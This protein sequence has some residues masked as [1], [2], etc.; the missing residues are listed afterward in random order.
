MH[1]YTEYLKL[2]V[3][4]KNIHWK[5][6]RKVLTKMANKYEKLTPSSQENAS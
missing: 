4:K 2:L 6:E 1:I 5:N 3:D